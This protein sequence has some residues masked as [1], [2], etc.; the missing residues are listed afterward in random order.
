MRETY[1]PINKFNYYIVILLF[2]WFAFFSISRFSISFSSDR[3]LGSNY[4]PFNCG[5][6]SSSA[7]C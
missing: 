4:S 5:L 3:R 7:Y 6:I 2:F 1:I